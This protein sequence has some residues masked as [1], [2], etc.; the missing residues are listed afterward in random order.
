MS[1]N[2]K[3]FNPENTFKDLVDVRVTTNV[4]EEAIAISKSH[5][6][7]ATLVGAEARNRCL[8]LNGVVKV[9]RFDLSEYYIL[10]TKK[11]Y[12][13]AIIWLQ[14]GEYPSDWEYADGEMPV[15]YEGM[16]VEQ[17]KAIWNKLVEDYLPLC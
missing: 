5:P 15:G 10:D 3:I 12:A 14:F 7:L 2:I 4:L 6:T 13:G 11:E 9:D 16:S 8:I 17:V 1:W